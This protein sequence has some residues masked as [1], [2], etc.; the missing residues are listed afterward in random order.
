MHDL[1]LDRGKV[2]LLESKPD[3]SFERL[4][5]VA[6][7]PVRAPNPITNIA[8]IVRLPIDA[9][10]TDKRTFSQGFDSEYHAVFR[11]GP[12]D[13]IVRVVFTERMRDGGSPA[14]HF[15]VAGE[16]Y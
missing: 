14:R 16:R 15:V 11:S 13:I 12:F 3:D 8:P 9:N 2:C 7:P 6:P 4:T 10:T 5:A 1:R